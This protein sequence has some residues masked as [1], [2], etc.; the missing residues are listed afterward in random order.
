LTGYGLQGEP[1]VLSLIRWPAL[2][3]QDEESVGTLA[4]VLTGPKVGLSP[5][6][7]GPLLRQAPWLLAVD[8]ESQLLAV[9]EFLRARGVSDLG[10]VLR[11]F[12]QVLMIDVH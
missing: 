4:Q 7:L 12:P 1:L 9:T 2:L 11:A 8:V 5:E 6:V 10:T 3:L